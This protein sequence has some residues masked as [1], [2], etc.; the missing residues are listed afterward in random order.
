M[1]KLL[2][3]S[4]AFTF[5]L[6]A[7]ACNNNK[8]TKEDNSTTSETSEE[9]LCIPKKQIGK[10]TPTTTEADLIKLYGKKNVMRDSVSAGEGTYVP[11]TTIFPNTPNALSITWKDATTLKNIAR[12]IIKEKGTKWTTDKGITIGSSLKEVKKQNATDFY[13]FG[14][15]WDYYGTVTSWEDGNFEKSGFSVRLGYEGDISNL[16]QKELGKVLGD[17]EVS[18]S[19]PI[20]Q[21]MNVMVEQMY[22]FF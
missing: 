1:N 11:A 10:I 18:T 17:H 19:E 20:L 4:V 9:W 22:F 12:I 3:F 5:L 8:K 2:T 21:K 13:F 15:E 7:M 6:F 16:D 14:F